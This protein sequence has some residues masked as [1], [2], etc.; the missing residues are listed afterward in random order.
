M[1]KIFLLVMLH[2]LVLGGIWLWRAEP[3]V[4]VHPGDPA[5]ISMTGQETGELTDGEI[6]L[7]GLPPVDV[8][9]DGPARTALWVYLPQHMLQDLDRDSP[10]NIRLPGEGGE[11]FTGR[12]AGVDT[13]S[14]ERGGETLYRVLLELDPGQGKVGEMIIP[15]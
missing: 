1:R 15:P 4:P 5:R 3:D 11:V 8:D 2:I 12:V 13:V 7:P 14:R 9:I 6:H 10:V